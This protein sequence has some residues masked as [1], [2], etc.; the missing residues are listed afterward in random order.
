MIKKNLKINLNY[1]LEYQAF[2]KYIRGEPI[3][4]RSFVI[5]S[6][7]STLA[8]FEMIIRYIPGGIGY[9]IRYWYYKLMLKK[10]GK[11]VL[12]DV[13]VFL[14]GTKNIS[15]GDYTWIDAGCRIE[16]MLGEVKIGK[17]VHIAPFVI[18][19]ARKPLIVGD[20]VGIGAGAKIYANS[21][22]PHGGKRMSGPMIPEEYK[23]YYSKKM[24]IEKDSC[25]GTGSV[26]L[27]GANIG[28]GAVVGANTVIKRKV[29]PYD[30]VAGLPPRIIGKRAKV[31][32]PEL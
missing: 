24:V 11:N 14:Y 23:A 29:N 5:L 25:I 28:V 32:V 31:T 4:I 9:V 10:M 30:I 8:L 3:P 15:I 17:R 7:K 2:D 12:I 26:L 16:A 18:L 21:E 13:G 1:K 6:L 22:R 20:Y 27:P 19:A